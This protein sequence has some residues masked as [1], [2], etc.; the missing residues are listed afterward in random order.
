MTS[1]WHPAASVAVTSCRRRSGWPAWLRRSLVG[2]YPQIGVRSCDVLRLQSIEDLAG[3]CGDYIIGRPRRQNTDCTRTVDVETVYER[4]TSTSVRRH[5]AFGDEAVKL[6]RCAVTN[7]IRARCFS[8]KCGRRLLGDVGDGGPIDDDRTWGTSN[9]LSVIR[10]QL[11][12]RSTNSTHTCRVS[13]KSP[14]GLIATSVSRRE[15]NRGC[16]CSV[17]RIHQTPLF[18]AVLTPCIFEVDKEGYD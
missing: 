1:A 3:V 17:R 16:F 9:W 11:L 15:Q 2:T 18:T 7:E 14:V 5:V 12:L 6:F 4:H 8:V 10:L 13:A